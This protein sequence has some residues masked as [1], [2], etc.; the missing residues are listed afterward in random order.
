MILE[1][2]VPFLFFT[3]CLL[4]INNLSFFT[5]NTLSKN[6]LLIAFTAKAISAVFYGYL[7]KTGLLLGN[8]S[9]MYFQEGNLVFSTLKEHPLMFLKLEFG[10]NGIVPIPN[11][12]VSFM[13]DM[14]FWFDSGNY[15]LVRINALIRFFSFG[16][17]NAHAIVF[18]FLSFIGL[19]NLYLF[20]EDK[21]N[22]KR[23]LAFFLFAIP[24]VV[25]WTSG[26]HKEAIVMFSLGM[27]LYNINELLAKKN[28]RFNHFFMLILGLLS[29]GYVRLYL[30]VLLLPLIV[31]LIA[32]NVFGVR[33]KMFLVFV[34]SIVIF[35]LMLVFVD[36]S[37]PKLSILTELLIRRTYFLKS[38]GGSSFTVSGNIHSIE[39]FF[40]LI[41]EIIVNPIFRPFP[42]D[43]NALLSSAAFL[44]MVVLLL[45]M[46]KLLFSTHLSNIIHNQYAIFSIIFGVSTLLLIGIIVNNSGAIVRY[47]SV[48][49]PFILIGLCMKSPKN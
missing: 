41:W 37:T 29:L 45:I 48:V 35:L 34:V 42:T 21:V 43:G 8:D 20:Y 11:Y 23:L 39:G 17:Y 32:Y 14:G 28:Y 24:S 47:R 18:S 38:I 25:F 49:I 16:I 6:I 2:I 13:E 40:I 7:F 12:L 10:R 15:Y 3:I 36:L 30:L 9:Y 26:V 1:L 44:E 4:L 31:S 33:K 5:S 27:I 22:D 46:L 19:Y